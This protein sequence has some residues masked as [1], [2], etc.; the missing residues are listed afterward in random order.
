[1]EP[2]NLPWPERFRPRRAED[3]VG[4][5]EAV[6]Q[7]RRWLESW[8][9][10]IPKRRAML[11]VGPPGVGKTSA[12]G[13]LA[14]DLDAELVEF[15]A[16][17]KRN[18]AAIESGVWMAAT[19]ETIDGRMRIVLMDEIDGLSG[20]GDRGGIGAI[21]EVVE[22]TVHPMVL[23][24]NNAD[25]S[26]MKDLLKVC[27]SVEFR[28]ASTE[29]AQTMLSR[30]CEE[31][32][33]DL[34]SETLEVL[35]ER[36]DG[37]LRAAVSDLEML[38]AGRLGQRAE[39]LPQ[40]DVQR[41]LQESL[42]RLFM[43]VDSA[44]VKRVSDEIDA[45]QDELLLWLEENASL[46]LLAP[47]ELERG[48]ESLSLADVAL[49]RIMRK[50]DWKLLAYAYDF[51]LF[52]LVASRTTTPYRDVVYTEPSWPLM[53]WKGNRMRER[54]PLVVSRLSEIAQ[55]AENRA[56]RMQTDVI[57]EIVAGKP[58]LKSAFADWLQVEKSAIGSRRTSR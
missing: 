4:N 46:H 42:G 8:V 48:F 17:D 30:I 51:M 15:N 2:C 31:I 37:D 3:L 6:R 36:A 32:G 12:V 58:E 40:R 21:V 1:M 16:S 27:E 57:D 28:K 5:Q 56:V 13:A 25:S 35:A 23:T 41:R 11:L 44:S 52:G 26:R 34:D 43:S 49:G 45:D 47:D 39:G 24:A 20:T 19:Q 38:T 18:K 53:I 7:L 29:E 9:H 33:V 55:V 22:Q 10:G 14:N 54:E 50:Q